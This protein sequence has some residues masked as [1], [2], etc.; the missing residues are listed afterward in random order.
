[1]IRP[2]EIYLR[3]ALIVVVAIA[4]LA[5]ESAAIPL[6]QCSLDN[7][8][9]ESSEQSHGREP[10]VEFCEGTPPISAF[11]TTSSQLSF[12]PAVRTLHGM[13]RSEYRTF[14]HTKAVSSID[15]TTAAHRYGLYN[16]KILFASYPRIYY[17][18]RLMR[19]II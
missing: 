10:K 9:R 18:C 4:T 11:Q 12:S 17:L 15:S 3:I 6:A 7:S 8:I 13:S 2:R 14:A 16:H 1:M 19:L 5:T